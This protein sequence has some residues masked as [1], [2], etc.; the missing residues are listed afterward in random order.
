MDPQNLI[1]VLTWA[2]VVVGGGL[3]ST[4]VWFALRIVQ[5]LDRLEALLREETH[6]LDSR[7]TRLEDWRATVGFR[8]MHVPKGTD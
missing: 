1:S 3:V 2:L 4:L 7:V 5:Q 8:P 6:N